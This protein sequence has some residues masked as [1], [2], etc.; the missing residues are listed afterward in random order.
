MKTKKSLTQ[1]G[2]KKGDFE[3]KRKDIYLKKTIGFVGTGT[4]GDPM[5]QNL[6]KAGFKLMVYDIRS[7]STKNVIALGAKAAENVSEMA[8]CDIVFIMVNTGAQVEDVILGEQGI[9]HA[10][11]N[12]HP[13]LIVVMS[14]VSPILIKKLASTIGSKNVTIID[15]PV[16]GPPVV[17]QRGFLTFMVGGQEDTFVSI[18]PYLQ[19]MGK[20]IFYIGPLGSGLAMK[21][22]NNIIALTNMYLFPESLRIGLKAG[23]DIKTMVDVMRVS[24]GKTYFSDQWSFYVSFLSMLMKDSKSHENL[25]LIGIKDVQ[26]A[27][28]WAEELGHESPI[29][30]AI[31]HMIK[32]GAESTGVVTEELFNQIINAKITI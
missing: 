30:K 29:L 13:L 27:I 6:L 5:A 32:C 20:N 19:A 8:R 21:L 2:G 10:F 9:M 3:V 1:T 23:L 7:G 24:T 14:T 12:D 16:S 22:V 11:K 15:A 31:S 17:A 4:M 28:E 18:K 25:N 26:S